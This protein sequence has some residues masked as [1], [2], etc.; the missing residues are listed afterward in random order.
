[1]KLIVEPGGIGDAI[2]LT[3]LVK[4]LRRQSPNDIITVE[5]IGQDW[6]WLNNPYKPGG[7]SDSGRVIQIFH[8]MHVD[9]GSLPKKFAKQ[10][11]VDLLDD[12]PEIFLSQEEKAENFGITDWSRTIA[13]DTWASRAA[14]RWPLGRF[15]WAAE[16]LRK[17]G[18]RPIE[19]GRHEKSDT[20]A[21][22]TISC[23]KSFLNKLTLRQTAAVLARCTLYLGNDS[24]L[25]HLAA[26]VGTPQVTLFGPVPGR[27][28][29]YWNTTALGTIRRCDGCGMN[30][31]HQTEWGPE[32]LMQIG[33]PLVVEAV[34][35][36]ARRFPKR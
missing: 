5:G 3:P 36:A 31:T 8:A 18:W 33:H 23:E 28:R 16:E 25:F 15:R 26:A 22:S 10:A 9:A 21:E 19:V 13:I 11:G 1:M 32:C 29:A 2:S 7:A 34:E 30:C 17:R 12:T 6:V 14:R 20:L 27:F 35:L 24:G 4:A